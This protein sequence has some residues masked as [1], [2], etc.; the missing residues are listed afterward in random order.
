MAT[1]A[2]SLGDVGSKSDERTQHV[3]SSS[4]RLHAAIIAPR[5][6]GV[7]PHECS[8]PI[9]GHHASFEKAYE[10]R[11]LFTGLLFGK[12]EEFQDMLS[13]ADDGAVLVD[14]L[15]FGNGLTGFFVD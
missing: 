1:A 4:C 3:A 7:K 14:D 6:N 9:A 5:R 12:F 11:R 8:R 15:Y 10:I 13:D 2:H